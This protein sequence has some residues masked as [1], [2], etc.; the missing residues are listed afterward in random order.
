MS[1]HSNKPDHKSIS[2]QT[3]AVM[4]MEQFGDVDENNKGFYIR[5]GYDALEL[6]GGGILYEEDHEQSKVVNFQVKKPDCFYKLS[7][8]RLNG[9]CN[10]PIYTSRFK[11][12]CVEDCK[13][14]NLD[15]FDTNIEAVVKMNEGDTHFH[16]NSVVPDG[17]VVNISYL[18]YKIIDGQPTFPETYRFSI[19]N[20]IRYKKI[21]RERTRGNKTFTLADE[22][23]AKRDFHNMVT[24][25]LTQNAPT[26]TKEEID[27][28]MAKW[29]NFYYISEN[30]YTKSIL[31][32]NIRNTD[33][34]KFVRRKNFN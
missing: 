11:F 5:M 24:H 8:V 25:D 23:E 26:I 20:Y 18:K 21:V 31:D 27:Q 19:L 33:Y 34:D 7:D 10:P 14:T 13:S 29:H 22:R 4:A 32:N 28:I 15:V 12:G 3:I 1:E 16:F 6:I 9:F 17:T 30:P 2:A